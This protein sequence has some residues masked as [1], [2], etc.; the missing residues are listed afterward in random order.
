M[1]T[2]SNTPEYT[3]SVHYRYGR[4]LTLR[5]NEIS[6]DTYRWREII[7]EIWGGE[8]DPNRK[9]WI[10]DPEVVLTSI[11][12]GKPCKVRVFTAR[13]VEPQVTKPQTDRALGRGDG[14]CDKCQSW[15]FGDC[16]SH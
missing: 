13:P 16:E 3:L 15:C 9:V 6:G 12:A 7:R 14:W 11:E 5:G 2:N 4:G 10:V 1:N 8:W